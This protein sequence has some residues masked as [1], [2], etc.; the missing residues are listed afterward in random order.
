MGASAR[1]TWRSPALW[2]G[3]LG[4]VLAL[5]VAVL[6]FPPPGDD[7]DVNAVLVRAAVVSPLL[8]AGAGWAAARPPRGSRR[9]AAVLVRTGWNLFVCTAAAPVALVV[10]VLAGASAATFGSRDHA[11]ALGVAAAGAVIFGLFA[12]VLAG[13][14]VVFT[15]IGVGWF[16]AS[17]G[18]VRWP[19]RLAAAV[20][21][22]GIVVVAVSVVLAIDPGH[23]QWGLGILLSGLFGTAPIRSEPWLLVARLATVATLVAVVLVAVNGRRVQQ[24]AASGGTTGG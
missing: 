12:P 2:L 5:G 1:P 8:L 21:V 23:G 24:A 13:A 3:Q 10:L 4:W 22:V 15:G 16:T 14:A 9:P 11:D 17:R 7:L 18:V 6:L 19:V 20:M